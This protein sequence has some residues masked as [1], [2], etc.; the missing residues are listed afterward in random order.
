[1]R[2]RATLRRSAAREGYDR[3]ILRLA[4]PTLGSLLAEPLYILAD[5]AVVGHLGTEELGGLAVA[6]SLLV[7]GYSLF[8]FL[9]YGTTSSVA[10]L[11]GAGETDAAV[12]EGAQGIWLAAVIGLATS[13]AGWLL[14]EVLVGAMGAE[15]EVRSHA[16]TYLR[17]SLLGMP[18]LLVVLAGTGYLR[19]MQDTRTPLIVTV[20]ASAANLVLEL[21]LIYGFGFGIAASAASTVAVQIIAA[22]VFVWILRRDARRAGVSLAPAAAAVA[23]LAALGAG[24]FVRTASLRGAIL[25][26][27][28]VATRIGTVELGA[29]QIAFEIWN[30]LALCLDA[31]AIAGQAMIGRLLGSGAAAEARAVGRRMIEWGIVAGAI[32]GVP[33]LVVRH[34][35]PP[36]FTDDAEVIRLTAFLLLFVSVLQP[37]NGLVFVLDGILIGAGDARFLAWAMALAALVLFAGLTVVSSTEAGMG[38]VWSSI[39]VFMLA[40]AIGLSLRFKTSAWQRVGAR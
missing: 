22:A 21:V 6:G 28:A 31:I 25:A 3:E 2:S 11:V 26:S 39:G 16:L 4:L 5:T 34:L 24:L 33:I 23:S 18:A 35:L 12:R 1:M 17:I 10:R 29:H 30:L 20:A 8:I 38:A 37:L 40:R 13:A 32:I 9:A 19:G 36:L 15:G 14:A 27:T 7:A